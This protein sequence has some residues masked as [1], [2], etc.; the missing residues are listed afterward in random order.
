MKKLLA[1][2]TSFAMTLS[3]MTSAFASSITVSAAGGVSTVQPNVSMEDA[4]G[5]AANKKAPAQSTDFFVRGGK[6][7]IEAGHSLSEQTVKVDGKDY[8]ASAEFIVESGGHKAASFTV[9]LPDD[10]PDGITLSM[11]DNYIYCM[12]DGSLPAYNATTD[13]V[14]NATVFDKNSDPVAIADGNAAC[15]FDVHVDKDVKPGTYKIG[16]KR[17]QVV[18]SGS[19]PKIEFYA[20]VEPIEITV[21]GA[22]VTTEPKGDTTTAPA[23]T[24]TPAASTTKVPSSNDDNNL[25]V[26]DKFIIKGKEYT[27]EPGHALSEQKD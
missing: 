18:E 1:A 13:T 24:K 10:I 19:D 21:V 25:K 14:W 8:P 15:Q 2:A 23:T 17:F 9:E 3:V 20:V 16:L 22:A 6:Y 5:G 11:T 7:E 26:N 4:I 12:A 27:I